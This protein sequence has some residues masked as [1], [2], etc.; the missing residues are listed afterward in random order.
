MQQTKGQVI[1]LVVRGKQK[2]YAVISCTPRVALTEEFRLTV[3]QK[4][5]LFQG[6]LIQD[7]STTFNRI[8]FRVLKLNI[9]IELAIEWTHVI[10][11]C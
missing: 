8:V 3:T 2:Q 1:V 6:K 9:N 7:C 10:S 5:S 11:V 4:G